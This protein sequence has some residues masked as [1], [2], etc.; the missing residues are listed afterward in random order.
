M[1]SLEISCNDINKPFKI[2]METKNSL[3][4]LR[5]EAYCKIKWTKFNGIYLLRYNY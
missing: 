2:S 1:C 5:H 3:D 4:L